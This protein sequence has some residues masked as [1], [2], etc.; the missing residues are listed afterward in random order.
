VPAPES[1]REV[2][3]HPH[4]VLPCRSLT[5]PERRER[6]G[7]KESGEAAEAREARE[8]K[9]DDGGSG[10]LEGGG[11]GGEGGWVGKRVG[12]YS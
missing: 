7:M 2:V 12:I 1:E 4:L 9:E 8:E 11:G 3:E 5:S 10:G 6:G